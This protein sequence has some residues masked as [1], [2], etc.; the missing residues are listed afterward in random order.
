MDQAEAFLRIPKVWLQRYKYEGCPAF[1]GHRVHGPEVFAWMAE[2]H[3]DDLHAA[4]M[5]V[6]QES[7]LAVY[8]QL[9][10]EG[11]ESVTGAEFLERACRS[12]DPRLPELKIEHPASTNT[13][14][15]KT[16]TIDGSKRQPLAYSS[17]SVSAVA[18]R[19]SA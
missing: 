5:R 2:H 6:P 16:G 17:T 7:F 14:R 9:R 1:K 19:R 4:M 13:G 11:I 3:R 15:L 18:Q 12:L 8:E 10:V